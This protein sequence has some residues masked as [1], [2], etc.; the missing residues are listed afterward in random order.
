MRPRGPGNEDGACVENICVGNLGPRTQG[1]GTRLLC[2]VH[3][4]NPVLF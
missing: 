3:K 2:G 1:L 4:Q